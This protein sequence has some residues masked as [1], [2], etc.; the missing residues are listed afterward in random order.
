M[1]NSELFDQESTTKGKTMT[2]KVT[3]FFTFCFCFMFFSFLAVH[4][5]H[6]KT[7]GQNR[8]IASWTKTATVQPWYNASFKL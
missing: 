7:P 3:S 1:N 6:M 8:G 5:A 2:C 4:H